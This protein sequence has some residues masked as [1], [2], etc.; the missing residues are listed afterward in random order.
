MKL[1]TKQQVLLALYIEYQKDVPHMENVT[2]TA[3]NMDIDVFNIALKKLSS[4]G[5]ITDL[6]ILP[7]DNDEFYIV[8]V[9]NVSLTRDGIEY[10]ETKFGINKELTASDKVKYI[11]KKC[12][13]FGL[14]AL[15]IF[16]V[17][18]LTHIGDVF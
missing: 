4:E 11:I 13:V 5:Y 3:L 7:A 8:S 12:G 14:Q 6:F 9:H 15:K 10:V 1:D 2:C 18:A 16:G 17:E